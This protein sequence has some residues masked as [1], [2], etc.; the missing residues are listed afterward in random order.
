M[1]KYTFGDSKASTSLVSILNK[2]GNGLY[3]H[4]VGRIIDKYLKALIALER[5]PN[6]DIRETAYK[7]WRNHF[8]ER[9]DNTKFPYVIETHLK[10]IIVG[11]Y[12]KAMRFSH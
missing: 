6:K 2:E 11:E 12:R 4:K 10:S 9:T 7:L 1:D 5:I 8:I 3:G